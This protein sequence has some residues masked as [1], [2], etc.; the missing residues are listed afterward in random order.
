M[1]IPYFTYHCWEISK[2]LLKDKNSRRD[3]SQRKRQWDEE[4]E[5]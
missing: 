4:C 3:K 1:N 5:G 2:V